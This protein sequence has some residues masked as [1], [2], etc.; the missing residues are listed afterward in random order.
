MPIGIK[1]LLIVIAVI[2][3]LLIVLIIRAINFK[4]KKSANKEENNFS[5][6][7]DDLANHFSSFIKCKTLSIDDPENADAPEHEK[8]ISLIQQLYPNVFKKCQFERVAKYGLVLKFKGKSSENPSC[9]MSHYDVVP[10]T[11]ENW[12]CDPFEGLIKDGLVWGRGACDNKATLLCSMEAMEKTLIENPDYMPNDDIYFTYGG[13]EEINGACQQ[14]IVKKFEEEGKNFK[15]VLD[16]GGAIVE[17]IF[18]GVK[19]SVA[20]IGLC[21]KGISNVELSVTSTGGHASTPS[22]D[23]PVNVLARAL[24]KLESNPMRSYISTPIAGM[25]DTLGRYSSFALKIVFANM[26]LF[27]GLVKKIFSKG[28]ETNA[29][30]T[31]TF[32]YTTLNGSKAHNVLPSVASCNINIRIS[33]DSNIDEV[34]N[35]IKKVINDD[36]VKVEVKLFYNPSPIASIED[37][38]YQ[39]VKE[40]MNEVYPDVIVSPYIML[41][42]SDSRFYKNVSNNTL[43]FA[44]F[45]MTKQQRG[46]IHGDNENIEVDALYQGTNF[47]YNLFKKV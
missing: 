2:V 6:N 34:V 41:A 46:G 25:L 5:M 43:K 14:A 30:L 13:D 1:I 42:A 20:V 26:W 33:N 7:K 18:P 4:P 28:Q 39:T 23:N 31:T 38:G 9:I 29:M 35:H 44:P 21:E 40:A 15:L 22:K 10:V 16:E 47:Y 37:F 19:E 27:S 45:R 24:I 8:F 32:A 11:E 3:A 36:R 17:G 12:S